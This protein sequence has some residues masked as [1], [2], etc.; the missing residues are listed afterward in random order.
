MNETRED[1][2]PMAEARSPVFATTRWSVVL[3]AGE[4]P[5]AQ[6]AEALA[7]LCQAYWYPLY[8]YARREGASI[9]DAQ[10]LTQEFFARL[11]ER[12]YLDRADPNKGRFRW[13]LLGAL[14]HFLANQRERARSLRRG[15]RIVHIP[16][17]D[18]TAEKRYQ[19]ELSTPL[20]PDKNFDRAWALTL[21]ERVREQ[22]RDHFEKAGKRERFETL[23]S[24][25]PGGQEKKSYADMA[26]ELGMSEGAL[27]V[28]LHRFKATYRQLLRT[29]I[30]HTVSAP[31]EVDEELRYLIEVM[32]D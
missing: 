8:A 12:N 25:L 28:E 11:L 27:R 1:L 13:F 22:L 6:Q 32:R 7:Q 3:N 15:G 14:K 31:A 26:A 30:A 21:L 29:E 10:D 4:A 18:I 17:D 2:T 9:E 20:T 5:S 19:L 16:L 23:A 24:F